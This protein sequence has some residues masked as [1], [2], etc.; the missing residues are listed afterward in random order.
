MTEQQLENLVIKQMENNSIEFVSFKNEKDITKNFLKHMARINR[1]NYSYD[2]I[3]EQIEKHIRVCDR[4]ELVRNMKMGLTINIGA[5]SIHL[6]LLGEDNRL[7]VVQQFTVKGRLG[8]ETRQDLTLL[9][10]GM[11]IALIELKKPNLSGWKKQ[12]SNQINRYRYQNCNIS[13]MKF[14]RL[15]VISDGSKLFYHGFSN[16]KIDIM[17]WNEWTNEKNEE[18][19]SKEELFNSFTTRVKLL[20]T[21]Y[22]IVKH[23]GDVLVLRPYQFYASEQIIQ[24]AENNE[25]GYVWHTTGAGKTLTSFVTCELLKSNREVSKIIFL[26]DRNDLETQTL[27]EFNVFNTGLDTIDETDNTAQLIKKLKSPNSEK[28]IV[29]TIQKMNRAVKEHYREI[30]DML[31]KK[32]IFVVD[33]C[34]RSQSGDSHT[35]IS[36]AYKNCLWYGFTGTPILAGAND[37]TL[38]ATRDLFG[39]LL[40]RYTIKEAIAAG[41]VLGFHYEQ[42]EVKG[43]EESRK[44]HIVND[45]LGSFNEY[46]QSGNYCALFTTKGISNVVDY[47]NRFTKLS[48]RPITAI[49]SNSERV[50]NDYIQILKDYNKRFSTNYSLNNIDTFKKDVQDRYKRGELD[51]VLVDGML[52]TGYD[53][54]RLNTLFID[55]NLKEHGLIQAF[56]RTNRVL[57]AGKTEGYIVSYVDN[58]DNMIDALDTFSG[59]WREIAEI[60]IE[61]ESREPREHKTEEVMSSIEK[62]EQEPDWSNNELEIEN[63]KKYLINNKYFRGVQM[64]ELDIETRVRIEPILGLKD[65]TRVETVIQIDAKEY[66]QLNALM[67]LTGELHTIEDLKSLQDH[68]QMV[69]FARKHKI[70]RKNLQEIF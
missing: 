39:S 28:L 6:N 1:I 17:H 29:T 66:K 30:E 50:Q 7:E 59:G 18:F 60:N 26:L 45:V 67:K 24:A 25:N 23:S 44:S 2:M 49:F 56:S 16:S 41:R 54:K 53:N 33:E 57:D 14:V 61:K 38:T 37:G 35:N 19:S 48:D 69:K 46:T 9:L 70:S 27:G 68:R 20:L 64:E 15:F 11:P 40:H 55:K 43:E 31:G 42:C 65:K 10:N 47:Y 34:H 36:N 4:A 8:I 62:E 13:W 51:L 5:K 63:V 12:A 52:L 22:S 58:A 21:D 32:T 3:G